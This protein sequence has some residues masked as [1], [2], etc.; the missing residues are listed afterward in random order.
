[1]LSKITKG[2]EY[3]LIIL[4]TIIIAAGGTTFGL[5]EETIALYPILVPVF[6][7]AGY[8]VMVCI[9]AIYMGSSIGTMFPTINPIFRGKCIECGG[10]QLGGWN[11]NPLCSTGDRPD[12]YARIYFTLCK[13]SQSRSVTI[14]LLRSVRIPYAKNLAIM[15]EVPKFTGRM[16]LTLAVFGIT[17]AVLVLGSGNKAVVV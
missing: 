7:A 17:F 12:H 14:D 16:K 6:L 8:D 2:K 4:I 3:L 10:Y 5:A 1:M 15:G 9:A 13:E 11:G